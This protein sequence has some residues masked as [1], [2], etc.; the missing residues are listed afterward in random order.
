VPE[1][2]EW[3]RKALIH[4]GVV[5]PVKVWGHPVGGSGGFLTDDGVP[6]AAQSIVIEGLIGAAEGRDAKRSQEALANT[7]KV[8][9]KALSRFSSNGVV[10]KLSSKPAY[11]SQYTYNTTV[12]L[13]FKD[14]PVPNMKLAGALSW[15]PERRLVTALNAV[16]E[17]VT[18]VSLLARE[19]RPAQQDADRALKLLEGAE[20]VLGRDVARNLSLPGYRAA[21]ASYKAGEKAAGALRYEGDTALDK[22]YAMSDL[23][24]EVIYHKGPTVEMFAPEVK[25]VRNALRALEQAVEEAQTKKVKKVRTN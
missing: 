18:H 11:W 8:L 20:Q 10:A 4:S 3:V 15:T 13:Y 6:Y 21:A 23:L 17:A 2:N 25:A 24:S 7:R 1:L 12:I 14:A 19:S 9:T 5:G 16:A 22:V